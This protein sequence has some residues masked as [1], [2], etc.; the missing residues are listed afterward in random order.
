MMKLY[1]VRGNVFYHLTCSLFDFIVSH[2]FEAHFGKL[3]FR[4]IL[5]VLYLNSPTAQFCAMM[6]LL[7]NLRNRAVQLHFCVYS[8]MRCSSTKMLSLTLKN[9]LYTR[10]ISSFPTPS[11]F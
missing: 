3:L 11:P 8:T 4:Q 10:I 2:I 6:T 9:N 1:E 5:Y 7:N